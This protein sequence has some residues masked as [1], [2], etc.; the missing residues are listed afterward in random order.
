MC[1]C[2]LLYNTF[3]YAVIRDPFFGKMAFQAWFSEGQFSPF[4]D[5]QAGD[6]SKMNIAR[7]ERQLMLHGQGGNPDV[8]FRDGR[9]R[10]GE[11][12]PDASVMFRRGDT[13]RQYDHRR[14]EVLN[15]SEMFRGV[16]RKVRAA[17]EFA[18]NGQRQIER[19]TGQEAGAESRIALELRDDHRTIQEHITTGWHQSSRSCW[20]WRVPSPRPPTRSGIRMRFQAP[21]CRPRLPSP[22]TCGCSRPLPP[23]LPAGDFSIPQ[24]L[25]PVCSSHRYFNPPGDFG[26]STNDRSFWFLASF[27]LR[28]ASQAS[29]SQLPGIALRF[30]KAV[31]SFRH[32]PSPK[33][34]QK[35]KILAQNGHSYS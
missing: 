10:L 8:V 15:L 28:M 11:L 29:A 34:R 6:P 14:K 22:S 12:R 35:P 3:K 2:S 16:L 4:P 1:R 24:R 7:G 17:V 5:L 33:P 30:A 31:R 27:Q 9:A 18:Q 23:V 26:N 32:A 20:R 19:W 25:L 21:A 13:G